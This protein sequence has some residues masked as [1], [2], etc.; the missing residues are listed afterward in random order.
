SVRSSLV[1][2]VEGLPGVAAR[3]IKVGRGKIRVSATHAHP[4]LPDDPGASL[5]ALEPDG[6]GDRAGTGSHDSARGSADDAVVGA[7]SRV[8]ERIGMADSRVRTRVREA[9]RGARR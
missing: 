4:A 9:R 6:G 8:L 1:R 3:R 5:S 2:E 7:V